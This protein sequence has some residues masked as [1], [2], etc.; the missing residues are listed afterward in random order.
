MITV[1]ISPIVLK[2]YFF[3][4]KSNSDKTSSN[5][6]QESTI[7]GEQSEEET[8][9]RENTQSETTSLVSQGNI[10]IT[11][12]AELL[13]KWREVLINIDEI[14]IEDCRDLFMRIY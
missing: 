6:K 5:N 2:I 10:G 11:S 14:I 13:Q 12:S 8:N 4:L 9:R 7:T 3:L 1:C